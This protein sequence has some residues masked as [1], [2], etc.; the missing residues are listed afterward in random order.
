M[1]RASA[2]VE[3]GLGV[4]RGG[5]GQSAGKLSSRVLRR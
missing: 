3:E 1:G 5:P 2:D 4:E